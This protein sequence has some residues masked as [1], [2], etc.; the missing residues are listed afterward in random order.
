MK[1]LKTFESQLAKKPSLPDWATN[2][3]ISSLKL[4]DPFNLSYFIQVAPTSVVGKNIY[5]Y[6]KSEV[7]SHSY[8]DFWSWTELWTFDYS[9]F[10]IEC[11]YIIFKNNE[12][13][14][15]VGIYEPKGLVPS[16]SNAASQI[17]GL[18]TILGHET[19]INLWL[20]YDQYDATRI[21]AL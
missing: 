5:F 9:G 3:D 7:R 16:K 6:N 20:D 19:I 12:P 14:Y 10:K 18:V 13:T 11:G 21:D 15:V 1:Y 4:I 2:I 8:D 17:G